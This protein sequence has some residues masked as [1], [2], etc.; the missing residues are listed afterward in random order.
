MNEQLEKFIQRCTVKI[1]ID[2]TSA[3]GTGFFVTPSLILTC[4]HVVASEGNQA[5]KVSWQG[6]TN[7]AIA[8]IDRDHFLPDSYDLALLKFSS[9]VLDLPVAPLGRAIEPNHSVYA[10]GYTEKE[11]DFPDG[12]PITG[13][14]EGIAGG[15]PPLIKF[16]AGLFLKGLSGSPLVN[17]NTGKVCGVVSESLDRRFPLGGLAIPVQVIF[18]KWRD[19][20]LEDLNRE[21]LPTSIKVKIQHHIRETE[22]IINDADFESLASIRNRVA[23]WKERTIDFLIHSVGEEEASDIAMISAPASMRSPKPRLLSEVA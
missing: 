8:T 5:I 4:A 14:C 6:Q 13:L 7:F 23:Q 20:D 16:K 12:C 3:Q 22:K 17:L 21:K 2:G 11:G 18:S 10:Y 19:L 15:D 1:A 9:A